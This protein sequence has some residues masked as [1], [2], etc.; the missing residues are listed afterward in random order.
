MYTGK[1]TNG[2]TLSIQSTQYF[3]E[4]NT[5]TVAV[6]GFQIAL[7]NLNLYSNQI[8]EMYER[9]VLEDQVGQCLRF[10]CQF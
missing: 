4:D 2:I 3:L 8:T 9:F 6:T 10:C 1:F 7:N 5:T